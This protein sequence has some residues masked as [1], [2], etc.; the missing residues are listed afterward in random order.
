MARSSMEV[1]VGF[2]PF[3]ARMDRLVHGDASTETAASN[4]VR[5][6]APQFGGALPSGDGDDRADHGDGVHAFFVDLRS[7]RT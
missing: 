5:I 3:A 4:I 1:P 6:M 7:E 2:I